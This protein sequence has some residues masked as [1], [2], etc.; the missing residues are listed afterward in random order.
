[1]HNFYS[2]TKEANTNDMSS[3]DKCNFISTPKMLPYST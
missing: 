1:M 2:K 3:I